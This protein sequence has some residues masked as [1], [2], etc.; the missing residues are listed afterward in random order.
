MKYI[1]II[2]VISLNFMSEISYSQPTAT[3]QF[4]GGYSMPLGDYRGT[5]GDTRDKFTGNGNPDSNSYFMKSGIN[6]GIF[7]KIPVKKQ[8]PFNIKGGVAFNVFSQ[9]KEYTEGTSSITVTLKQSLFGLTMGSEYDFGGRKSKIRPFAG[10]ELSGIFFAGKYTE[11]YIDSVET[12]NLNAAFRLGVNVVAGVDVTLHNNIG[13]V[14]GAKYSFANLIGK[15]YEADTR[16]KY[17]LNDESY[18][19]NNI[20]YPS[21]NITFLQFYGGVSFYFGR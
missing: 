9:T 7:I 10:A 4:I 13:V 3:V 11:D 14:V 6:Y 5:F 17:N 12:Y 1:L 20:S 15:S 8:S 16:T 18:T 21:R 2:A 19:L